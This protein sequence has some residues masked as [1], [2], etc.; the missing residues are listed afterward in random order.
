MNPLDS[1]LE[2]TRIH[3]HMLS[4]YPPSVS[5]APITQVQLQ[6]IPRAIQEKL[7]RPSPKEPSAAVVDGGELEAIKL[8]V[9]EMSRT[10]HFYIPNEHLLSRREPGKIPLLI[11]LHGATEHGLLFRSSSTSYA[12]DELA[13]RE[14]FIVAYPDGYEGTPC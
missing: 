8:S 10:V 9:G 5:P 13:C 1:T 7:R 3:I 11:A 12:Y 6:A 4:A 2:L 14:G